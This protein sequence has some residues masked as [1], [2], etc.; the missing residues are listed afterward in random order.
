[1]NRSV[2]ITAA[3][4]ISAVLVANASA[5]TVEVPK[6]VKQ[7]MPQ[8]NE[9][10]APKVKLIPPTVMNNRG[11][12]ATAWVSPVLSRH[13][14]RISGEIYTVDGV[15]VHYSFGFTV[16]NPDAQSAIEVSLSC[17]RQNGAQ[18][19]SYTASLAAPRSGAASWESRG[20]VPERSTDRLTADQDLVWCLLHSDKPFVA[21]GTR[22]ESS[23]FG[24]DS[25]DVSLVPIAR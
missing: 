8:I 16:I 11:D 9:L 3:A 7:A 25:S 12:A 2:L 21:F 5:Q 22:W 10:L 4:L 24:S 23:K 6:S 19:P 15:Q 1:M 17:Y 14:S 13:D 18:H 20:V